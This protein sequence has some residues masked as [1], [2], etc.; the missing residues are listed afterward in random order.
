MIRFRF[1]HRQVQGTLWRDILF[2]GFSDTT[3]SAGPN[4]NEQGRSRVGLRNAK[5][6]QRFKV[7]VKNR[8][9]YR[10]EGREW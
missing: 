2:R 8:E 3:E 9:E 7:G 4:A 5:T 1:G 10:L 6:V